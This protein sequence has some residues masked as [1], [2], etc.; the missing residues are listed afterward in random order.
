MSV[1]SQTDVLIVGG[2]AIGLCA[3]YYLLK[4]GASV[5]VVDKGEMGHGSSLHN[6][7]YICPSHFVPLAAPGVFGQ[8]VKWMFNPR[9]PFYVKPRVSRELIAWAWEFR[10]SSDEQT[11]RRAMPVLRDLLLDGSRLMESLSHEPGMDFHFTRQGLCMLFQSEAGRRSALHEAALA[12]ELKMEARV[13]NRE[14]LQ[15]LDPGVDFCARGGVFYPGDAHLVPATLV[16]DMALFLE[17]SGATI[18]RQ[19]EVQTFAVN[20]NRVTSVV[21]SQGEIRAG[22]FVLA[23]G[24]W[25]PAIARHLGLRILMQPGKGYSITYR[26]PPVKP[27]HPYILVERRVAVTPFQESLRLAGTM[28][29]SG[30]STSINHLRVQAI[31]DAVPRYFRNVALTGS[32]EPTLWAGLRPVSPDGMPYI[33]RFRQY[34]NLLAATG[35]A[36]LGI[37]LAT[38]TGKLVTEM[39]RGE[40]PSHDVSLLNPHRFD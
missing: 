33:G 25:S 28:E 8:A 6:A 24:A 1:D 26:N 3:A 13:L 15:V 2:G 18:L 37:S 19:C 29:L 39:I 38:V 21:T 17:R 30:M 40:K 31:L 35:H 36:M 7:G 23:G 32:G 11:M 9:S 20:G 12:D 22:E 27:V 4:A 5:T 16:R 10:R 34:A 14:D